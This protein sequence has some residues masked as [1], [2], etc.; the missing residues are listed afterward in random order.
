MKGCRPL[1]AREL[2]NALDSFDGYYAKRNIAMLLLGAKS[3][4]RVSELLSIRVKDV[5]QHR[6]ITQDI[7]VERKNMK[8]KIEGRTVFLNEMAQHALLEWVKVLK[9]RGHVSPETFV[10]K[11][12]KGQ[13]RPISKVQAWRILNQVFRDLGFS[14]KLGTHTMRKTFVRDVYDKLIEMREDDP[15]VDPLPM[16]Q[17][18]TGHK[19]YDSLLKYLSFRN[20]PVRDAIRSI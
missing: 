6:K 14:G 19:S 9:S 18:A 5:V 20:K 13:N 4:F 12:R 3:G 15:S 17:M 16:L 8:R 11:S 2:S 10:F 7:T 1:K